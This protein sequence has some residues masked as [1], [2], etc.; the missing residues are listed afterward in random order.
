MALDPF[1]FVF[2]VGG[3]IQLLLAVFLLGVNF[4]DRLNRVLALFLVLQGGALVFQAI[5][6]RSVASPFTRVAFYMYLTAP[7]AL[8]YL[9][10]CYRERFGR[11]GLRRIAFPLAL[12]AG[13]VLAIA[14]MVARGLRDHNLFEALNVI[15]L[16]LFLFG[17]AFLAALLVRDATR[18]SSHTWSPQL[19]TAGLAFAFFPFAGGLHYLVPPLMRPGPAEVIAAAFALIPVAAMVVWLFLAAASSAVPIRRSARRALSWL[20]LAPLSVAV[21]LAVEAWGPVTVVDGVPTA[22]VFHL[23]M[24]SVMVGWAVVGT[25]LVAYAIARHQLFGIDR[26]LKWTV[27]RGTLAGIFHAIFVVAVQLTEAFAQNV[28]GQ[29]SWVLG[30][31][32]AAGGVFLLSPLKRF[33]DRVADTALPDVKET[34]AYESFRRLQMYQSALAAVWEDGSLRAVERRRLDR[35][36]EKLGIS[37]PDARA[38]EDDFQRLSRIPV[39]A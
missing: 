33:A 17:P 15:E 20:S 14:L 13:A 11:P 39:R 12:A 1:L 22:R 30:A 19:M 7:L 29:Y 31:I 3:G 5:G 6:E 16:F 23:T 2:Y 36:R 24:V 35:L 38:L 10:A 37:A 34:P 27:R 9:A 25:C 28:V 21:L 8:L 4:S 32:A 18:S 26:R